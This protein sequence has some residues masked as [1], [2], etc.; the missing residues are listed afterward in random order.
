MSPDHPAADAA[1]PPEP[2]GRFQAIA[3]TM[4]GVLLV[5]LGLLTLRD[6][7][8]A[9]AWAAVIAIAAW[10]LFRRAKRRWPPGKH[11]LLLPLLFTLVIGLVFL[12]PLVLI[13]VE[14]GREARGVIAWID[15][16]RRTGVPVPQW[17]HRLPIGQAEAS[18][19]W[20]EN[21]TDP[22]DASDLFDSIRSGHTMQ[23]TRQVG[24]QVAHRA[25]LFAF[26]LITLFF[27]FREGDAV[28]QQMRRVSRRAFGTRGE[29][30]GRQM[31]ASVHGTVDG[32]VLV[33]LGEGALLGVAYAVAGTPHPTLFGVVTA[34]AAMIPF[35]AVIA[36]A[37]ASALA[38]AGGS[39]TAA[40]CL[41]VFGMV[42]IFVADHFVRP[43][44]IG[45]ATKLPFLWVLLG[46][47]G[48]VEFWGL[49]GLFVGPAI[50]AA[51]ILLWRDWS[52]PE[53]QPI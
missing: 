50:M 45:G 39:A 32:L 28:V 48:G 15:H 29:H 38:L 22:D 19:L 49:L 26:T 23:L 20:Q 30:I 11:N 41:F 46:I 33:G 27:L 40:I 18:R 9:L 47:L 1:P 4:L 31:I 37:L 2:E 10:P 34:V 43:V 25:T 36:V 44:L 17:I 7:L 6:F 3:R 14:A 13:G 5:V 53:D 16:A 24:S 42:V 35:C 8:P 12:V 21:L 51:L 52:R